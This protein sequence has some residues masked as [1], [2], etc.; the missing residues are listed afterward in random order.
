MKLFN[1]ATK[2]A[3]TAG[4]LFAFTSLTP[5][6]SASALLPGN[7]VGAG[8]A[9]CPG[10]LTIFSD[11]ETLV[12]S[13]SSAVSTA[14]YSGTVLSAV[15]TN[16]MGTL[17]FLFQY[18]NDPRSLDA[19]ER[20][21]PNSFA[22]WTTDVGY[23][24]AALGAFG[25][26]SVSPLTVDRTGDGAVVGFNFASFNP[27]TR[28]GPGQ[29]SNI[30]EIRTTATKYTAGMVGVL[31]G[32]GSTALGYQPSAVPEPSSLAMLGA[33]LVGLSALRRKRKA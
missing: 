17:D 27:A 6:A 5:S 25:A 19:I 18:I 31:D 7:C 1:C 24:T 11:A 21:T 2:T 23:R 9:G 10:A 12:A 4:I 16:S 28:V 29:T 3:I 26:G 33:G 22:G 13:Q 32:A 30:L 15:Y 8:V 14:R 20:L